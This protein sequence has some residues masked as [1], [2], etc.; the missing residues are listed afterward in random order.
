[1]KYDVDYFIEKFEAIPEK[2]WMEGAFKQGKRKCA[3]G[4]CG[5]DLYHLDCLEGNKLADLLEP[6]KRTYLNKDLNL[7]TNKIYLVTATIN[8]GDTKEY[9]QATPKQRILAALYD[10]KKMQQPALKTIIRYV[11]VSEKIRND[12]PATLEEIN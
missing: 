11:A 12:V 9:Q 6:L 8:D 3:N 7:Y 2:F 4:H 1:M 10:I 5:V